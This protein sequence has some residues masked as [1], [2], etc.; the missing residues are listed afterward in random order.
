M[1]DLN[2]RISD[3][4]QSLSCHESFT[5]GNIEEL[6]S[7]LFDQI[8]ELKEAGLNDEEAYWVAQKRIGTIESLNSEYT[9]INNL[10][11]LKKKIYW[12]LTGIAGLLMYVFFVTTAYY[13]FISICMILNFDPVSFILINNSFNEIIIIS[14]SLLILWIMTSK[15]SKLIDKYYFNK[16]DKINKSKFS[17]FVILT[18]IIS[19]VIY[20]YFTY[21]LN[22]DIN[23][24]IVNSESYNDFKEINKFLNPLQFVFNSVIILYIYFVSFKTKKKIDI[25]LN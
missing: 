3:W 23:R 9:K 7:H 16:W 18:F 20:F 17:L 22:T 19:S 21:K 6:E 1:F 8:T 24:W 11:I 10:N 25:I 13:I 12:M 4:K 15:K 2:K 14:V 5:K